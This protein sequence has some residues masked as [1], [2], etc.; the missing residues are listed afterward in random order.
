LL[1]PRPGINRKEPDRS[2]RA[3]MPSLN[4]PAGDA[5]HRPPSFMTISAWCRLC[6]IS[7]ITG[8]R[9][10]RGGQGP[11]VTQL[12][13]RRL[14]IRSDHLREWLDSRVRCTTIEN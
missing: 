14:A 4:A 1:T 2:R 12:S 5:A 3:I 11:Q 13:P 9:L 10:L 7:K 6:G 8:H